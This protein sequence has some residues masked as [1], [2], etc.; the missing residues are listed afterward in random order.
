[1]APPRAAV[2]ELVSAALEELLQ[3]TARV[4]LALSG[5]LEPLGARRHLAVVVV[6]V[7]AANNW[8]RARYSVGT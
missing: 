3:A 7:C 2:E 1:M 6:S 8:I 5:E 4:V